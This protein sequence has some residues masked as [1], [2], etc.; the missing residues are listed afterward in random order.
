MPLPGLITTGRVTVAP[1]SLQAKN[2]MDNPNAVRAESGN[3]RLDCGKV[4]FTLPALSA[5]VVTIQL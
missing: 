1:G 5:A 2:S 4:L 3:V